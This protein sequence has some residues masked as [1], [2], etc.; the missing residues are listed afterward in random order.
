[1]NVPELR[2]V[3]TPPG[4]LA[5][6]E[7]VLNLVTCGCQTGCKTALCSLVK[8]TLTCSE[9]CKCMGQT[10]Y[11]NSLKVT[12]PKVNDSRDEESE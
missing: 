2:P 12:A 3:Y 1:M 10:S 7:E 9:L 6:P 5:A 4:Q 8:F 11:Q